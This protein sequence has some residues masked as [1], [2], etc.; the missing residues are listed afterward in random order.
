MIMV[1]QMKKICIFLINCYQI[2]PLASH[3]MC[4]FTPTCSEYTKIAIERF[5]AIK[6]IKLGVKRILKCHPNGSYGYDAVPEKE[7]V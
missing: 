2:L 1:I 4:R 7:N 5:G 6:G 3:K